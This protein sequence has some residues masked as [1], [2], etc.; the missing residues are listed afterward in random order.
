MKVRHAIAYSIDIDIAV[1][2]REFLD[3]NT[4]AV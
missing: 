2:I 1:S 4:V 3:L